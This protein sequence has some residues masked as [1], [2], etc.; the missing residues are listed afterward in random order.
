MHAVEASAYRTGRTAQGCKAERRQWVGIYDS[1]LSLYAP[2][3]QSFFDALLRHCPGQYAVR[4][5]GV[6][7]RSVF[8]EWAQVVSSIL[9]N[10]RSR[11]NQLRAFH[12]FNFCNAPRCSSSNSLYNM[13]G[14]T[15]VAAA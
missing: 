8:R 13:S 14:R 11:T 3:L 15:E 9:D 10:R 1:T 2:G 6:P 7:A 5:D 12:R 4:A